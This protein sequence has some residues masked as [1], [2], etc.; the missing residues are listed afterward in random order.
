MSQ[1]VLIEPVRHQVAIA[2]RV[3]NAQT[4]KAIGGA[5]VM[6]TKAPEE[7][8]KWLNLKSL[9]YGNHWQ[10]MVERPDR[11]RSAV[12][13]HFHFLDLP[14]GE[15]RLTTSLLGAGKRY[16]T[17]LVGITVSRQNDKIIMATADIALPPTTIKGKISDQNGDPVVLAEVWVN[18]STESAYS[19]QQGQYLLMELEASEKQERT[20]MV[21]A[22]GYEIASVEVLLSQAGVEKTLDF[23]LK[24]R[25]SVSTVSG[26]SQ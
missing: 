11:T 10:V 17:A 6:I 7:F 20:V 1:W 21:S 18:R 15:Y 23:V 9:Q 5:N 26:A 25:N 12:D 19:N 13:G 24:R 4:K 2:G 8:T 22:P 16:D 3:I 14:N